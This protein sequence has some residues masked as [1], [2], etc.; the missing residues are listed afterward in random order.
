[1]E[2]S[3]KKTQVNGYIGEEVANKHQQC[4]TAYGCNQQRSSDTSLVYKYQQGSKVYRWELLRLFKG[5]Q[6]CTGML[7]EICHTISLIENDKM[8]R[9]KV[10][11]YF[12]SKIQWQ[13]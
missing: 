12:M 11:C 7:R 4:Y 8:S 2:H 6:E 5:L 13:L 9:R 10:N 3:K 1:M